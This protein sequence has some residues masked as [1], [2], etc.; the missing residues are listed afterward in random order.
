MTY[1]ERLEANVAREHQLRIEV[2]PGD[3]HVEPGSHQ[4]SLGLADIRSVKKLLRRHSYAQIVN[5]QIEEFREFCRRAFDRLR[6][7]IDEE[8]DTVLNLDDV[9]ID[10]Q[11]L[12]LVLANLG[13]ET[14]DTQLVVAGLSQKGPGN[15]EASLLKRDG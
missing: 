11:L 6:E 8:V 12:A 7:A 9:L 4:L 13:Q 2:D 15:L 3:L 1:D 14:L 5:F 10:D